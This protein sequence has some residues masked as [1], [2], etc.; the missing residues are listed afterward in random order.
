MAKAIKFN[1][2]WGEQP[3]RTIA[4]LQSHFDAGELLKGYKSGTLRRW[5]S[6]RGYEEQLKK[7]DAVSDTDDESA[8]LGLCDVFAVRMDEQEIQQCIAELNPPQEEAC[9]DSESADADENASAES[10]QNSYQDLLQI[11]YNDPSDLVLI[12]ST[13]KLLNDEHIDELKA[14]GEKLFQQLWD[15][16]PYIIFCFLM[17]ENTR[18]LIEPPSARKSSLSYVS[19]PKLILAGTLETGSSVG[20]T[21]A[22]AFYAYTIWNKIQDVVNSREKIAQ[23]LGDAIKVYVPNSCSTNEYSVAVPA[24]QKCLILTADGHIN[25]RET[26]ETAP[27]YSYNDYFS[28]LNSI[29][30]NTK[31]PVLNGFEYRNLDDD[32]KSIAYLE[33]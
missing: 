22:F 4:D 9:S 27:V 15:T 17:Y 14:D 13:V 12:R 28:T 21:S 30:N 6:S 3:I 7:L 5:L 33:V 1:L 2:V 24:G 32:P 10:Q 18:K 20:G 23:T 29:L 8:L 11:L 25:I 16:S 19:A 31:I 26:G